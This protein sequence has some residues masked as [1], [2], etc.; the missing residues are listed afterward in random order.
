MNEA[1]S[2]ARNVPGHRTSECSVAHTCSSF[3]TCTHNRQFIIPSC[4]WALRWRCHV[5]VSILPG[6]CSAAPLSLCFPPLSWNSFETQRLAISVKVSDGD[7]VDVVVLTRLKSLTPYKIHLTSLCSQ[8]C[9][10][11]VCQCTSFAGGWKRVFYQEA[12]N[13]GLMM[14]FFF[15]LWRSMGFQANQSCWAPPLGSGMK[16]KD[17]RR[18]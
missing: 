8:W 17:L 15:F 12:L 9:A 13:R 2:S 6:R 3:F 10:V 16:N 7:S 11:A 18:L 5:A 14:L 1:N 4:H